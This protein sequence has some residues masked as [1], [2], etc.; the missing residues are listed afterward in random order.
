MPALPANVLS[1]RSLATVSGNSV[2]S[3]PPWAYGLIVGASLVCLIA[4]FL[5][6]KAIR[7]RSSNVCTSLVYLDLLSLTDITPGLRYFGYRVSG[8]RSASQLNQVSP[9]WI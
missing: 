6:V 4:G 8:P 5:V 3:L 7:R 9:N 1:D 2:H